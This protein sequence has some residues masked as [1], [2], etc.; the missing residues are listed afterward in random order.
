[1]STQNRMHAFLRRAAALAVFVALLWAIQIV[2][3]I[4]GY[5][6]N[7][8]FGLVPRH[9]GG[10]DGI[11]AMPLLHG[12]FAHLIANTPPLLVETAVQN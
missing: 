1:M 7:S 2:N 12:S 11:V 10:M 5:S 3:W 4:S 6:L 8:A 9:V